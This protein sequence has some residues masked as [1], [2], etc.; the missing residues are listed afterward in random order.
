M[1]I[2][3]RHFLDVL[4]VKFN[5]AVVAPSNVT[6]VSPTQITVIVPIGAGSGAI[7]VVT[8]SGTVTSGTNFTLTAPG[9][10]TISGFTPGGAMVGNQVV[11]QGTNLAGATSVLFNGVSAPISATSA[12]EITVTVPLNATTGAIQ[13]VT[14]SGIASSGT[15]FIVVPTPAPTLA[16]LTP[17]TAGIG[18][19]IS[20][21]GANLT[22]T[23]SVTINGAPASFN[24]DS[25]THITAT[26]PFDATNGRSRSPPTA[27]PRRLP[28]SRWRAHDNRVCSGPQH[29]R[30][31]RIF[32]TNFNSATQVLFNGVPVVSGFAIGRQQNHRDG[33]GAHHRSHY[34]GTPGGVASAS[35]FVVTTLAADRRQ[36][37][38]ATG[39]GDTVVLTGTGLSGPVLS[40]STV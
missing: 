23:T 19:S 17:A 5:G 36:H 33:S 24:V 25:P 35:N 22:G 4:L 9:L 7:A 40:C 30:Q 29:R 27:A 3:G 26:V 11:I 21:T 16:A 34:R 31:R 38:P 20:I 14:P 1:T 15:N 18:A 32:G 2:T 37:P 12:T 6:V 39:A 8:G 13:V 10:P 28:A